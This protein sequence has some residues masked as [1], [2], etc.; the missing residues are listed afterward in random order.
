MRVFFQARTL[1]FVLAFYCL[2]IIRFH[3]KIGVM[4]VVSCMEQVLAG[5]AKICY[6]VN[7]SRVQGSEVLGSPQTRLPS[8]PA[9]RQAGVGHVLN[10]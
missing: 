8:L 9:V 3:S 5:P 7:R 1:S 2:K 6:R 4:S 10:C